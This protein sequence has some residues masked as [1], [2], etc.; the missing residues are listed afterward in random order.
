MSMSY[1][2][3]S[4]CTCSDEMTCTYHHNHWGWLRC[5]RFSWTCCRSLGD[6]ICILCFWCNGL[7][8]RSGIALFFWASSFVRPAFLFCPTCRSWLRRLTWPASS[9]MLLLLI[10][11]LCHPGLESCPFSFFESW[12]RPW[13]DSSWGLFPVLCRPVFLPGGI[14]RR[15]GCFLCLE[16]WLYLAGGSWQRHIAIFSPVRGCVNTL[17]TS[18][19]YLTGQDFPV[20]HSGKSPGSSC[21][22]FLWW[23]RGQL[24]LTFSSWVSLLIFV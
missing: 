7:W 17:R 9:R 13:S 5:F 2:A 14:R 11:G 24:A 6:Q 12:R 3:A 21:S 10:H 4:F 22:A 20:I 1:V 19:C 23:N 18:A 16:I 15:V 8:H